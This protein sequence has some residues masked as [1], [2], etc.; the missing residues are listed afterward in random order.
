ME[1]LRDGSIMFR[2]AD[3]CTVA[4]LE[5]S[6]NGSVSKAAAA[7][8]ESA[9]N[10]GNGQLA[11]RVPPEEAGTFIAELQSHTQ[12]LGNVASA[13]ASAAVSQQ[14]R[15]SDARAR[16]STRGSIQ[17]AAANGAS[18]G[19][20]AATSQDALVLARYGLD[21]DRGDTFDFLNLFSDLANHGQLSEA[22][23]VVRS[24]AAVQPPRRDVLCRCAE[25]S[26]SMQATV[27]LSRLPFGFLC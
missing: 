26:A 2:F 20:M 23:A 18:L 16:A 13:Q 9:G 15:N 6:L 21:A 25:T 8:R 12:Q 22:L 27:Q 19:A 4:S 14:R 17:P 10:N 24:L 5:S 11:I 3:T 1:V 7:A